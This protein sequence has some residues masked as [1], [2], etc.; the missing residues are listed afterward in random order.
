V[1]RRAFAA[2]A[3]ALRFLVPARKQDKP[4]RHTAELPPAPDLAKLS[5]REARRRRHA[6]ILCSF[7]RQ[8]A[9]LPHPLTVLRAMAPDDLPNGR[10]YRWVRNLRRRQAR[11]LAETLAAERRKKPASS[12][13]KTERRRRVL[14]GQFGRND[15]P[16]PAMCKAGRR[17]F[18]MQDAQEAAYQRRLRG[19]AVAS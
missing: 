6:A 1:I 3:S 2:I 11:H 19:K 17:M 8:L 18:E 14:E 10:R 5:R 12:I 9:H 7:T 4:A 15:I 16:V 13:G